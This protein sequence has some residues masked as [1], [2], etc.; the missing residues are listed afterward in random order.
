MRGVERRVR[1]EGG[2]LREGET[3]V[4]V[5]LGW[6]ECALEGVEAELRRAEGVMQE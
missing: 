1:G 6:Q 2:R 4:A 5:F 3:L